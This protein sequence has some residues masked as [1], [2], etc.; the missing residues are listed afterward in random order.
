MKDDLAKKVE[1]NA[2]DGVLL[3]EKEEADESREN[4]NI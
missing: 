2:E 3:A 1:Y 4:G